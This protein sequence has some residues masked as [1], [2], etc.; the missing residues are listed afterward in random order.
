[1]RLL[2]SRGSGVSCL[3]GAVRLAFRG[4][5]DQGLS[6]PSAHG[7]ERD[8]SSL[9]AEP[10]PGGDDPAL[11]PHG[12]AA[13][14]PLTGARTKPAS[15]ASPG[16]L[17]GTQHSHCRPSGLSL[18]HPLPAPQ[19]HFADNPQ[20][21]WFLFS[22]LVLKLKKV[23]LHC[24]SGGGFEGVEINGIGHLRSEVLDPA[25]TIRAGHKR[26]RW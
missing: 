25:F 16:Q 19:S 6:H 13:S 23:F 11:P 12:Q 8:A 15:R 14:A 9:Q 10:H 20:L 21:L 22:V 3:R 1:M 7:L 2:D 17:V 4:G 24:H 18:F 26:W 5:R